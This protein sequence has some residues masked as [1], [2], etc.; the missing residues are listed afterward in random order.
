M[1]DFTSPFW[2]WYIIVLTAGGFAFVF[3][4]IW[5]QSRRPPAAVAP[6]EEH[7]WDEDLR[8]LNNP[9]PRWWL[10]LFFLTLFFGIV[11]LALY[12]GLGAYQGLLGWTQLGQY[13]TE[14]AEAD[15]VYDPI[16]KRF[17]QVPIPDLAQDPVA[18]DIGSR[19][20]LTY[21]TI[22]HGSDARGVRGFPNLRDHDWLWGGTP[23]Q[24]TATITNG[25]QGV[26]A[27]WKD[28]L[29][30][31]EIFNVAQ[32]V[33]SL[34]GRQIDPVVKIGGEKVYMQYCV[35]CHGPTGAGNQLLGAPNLTDDIWVHGNSQRAI[36]DVISEGRTGVMPPHGEFLGEAR[37]HLLATYIYS[38]SII[39]EEEE[40]ED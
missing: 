27:A 38:L 22:C 37:I 31:E 8:E 17:A 10:S 40:E 2:S 23:E 6:G 13:Q 30:R 28:V 14:V 16:Y 11:Y 20:Y 7:V 4:V 21:C 32:Y 34:S 12:P 35:A 5:S 36:I 26:M 25:R 9:L 29:K 1:A 18:L 24:I 3:F 15:A 19:L 33:R 39:G